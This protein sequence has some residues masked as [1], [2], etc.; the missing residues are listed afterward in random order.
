MRNKKTEGMAAPAQV[1]EEYE[2]GIRFKN[3][4]GAHGMFEQNRINERFYSGDQWYGARCG[5]DRPLVRY[6]VIQRIGKYKLAMV[7]ANPVAVSYSADGIPNTL[8]LRDRVLALKKQYAQG[9]LTE[10][11]PPEE[12]VNLVM[13]ALSD[14]FAVTAERVKLEDL[15]SQVLLN[16]YK[17]GDGVLFTY[18]D[19][20]V[21]TGLYADEQRRVPITGDIA[22]EVLDI[23]NVYFGDPNREE[24]QS[25]PYILIAQ[26]RRV[27]ELR[28][29][30]RRCG[31]GETAVQAIKADTDYGHT[32]GQF[33]SQ[34]PPESEKA[35]V[36]TKLWKE[37]DETGTTY[38]VKAV[39][40]T[41]DA[42]VRPTWD[43]GVRLYPLARFSWET[44]RGSAYGE[45]EITWLIPNQIAINRMI[46]AS[47]WAGMMTGMPIMVVNGD[48]VTQPIT[49][50]PGQILRVFGSA[51]D[52]NGAVRYVNPPAFTA[53]FEH[54]IADLIENTLQQAGANDAALGNLRP[55]NASAIIAVREAATM[56]MQLVQNR[57]YS[58]CEDVAR[59]WAEFWVMKYGRRSLK[60]EDENGVWYLPFDGSRFRDLMISVK[61]DVG[62]SSLWSE[63]Q[64][65]STLDNLF[66]HGVI[67]V[68]QYL[69]RL[70]KG[71][72]PNLNGL[73]R[74][75]QEQPAPIEA[76]ES[77]EDAEEAL[78]EELERQ[79]PD[80]M[81]ALLAM[82]ETERR[83]LMAQAL[84]GGADGENG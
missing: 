65:V 1:F 44:R 29:E 5:N 22:C 37:W 14:Y 38:T 77:G 41:R 49:N 10:S 55:D 21:K 60:V 52:V 72:V 18:W 26:R 8:A 36:I 28:R 63:T 68:R 78:L 27:A 71:T 13:S 4:L 15:K 2:R 48:V 25:Q 76:E 6:N 70:P 19:D 45:S 66:E 51:E 43:L 58:F 53:G 31:L 3:G 39:R 75:L 69:S 35:V 33:G 67:N 82:D 81:Q 30:A 32:A 46:T 62:A 34:E 61:V 64:S 73:L 80:G 47:V 79:Y 84:Q 17:A 59:I 23:E 42:V 40:V 54:N 7:S 24:L 50:D 16:A 9:E 56:P 83:A 12:E 57:F 11:L 74:E 20:G